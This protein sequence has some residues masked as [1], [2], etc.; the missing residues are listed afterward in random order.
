MPGARCLVV[1]PE[2]LRMRKACVSNL[3]KAALLEKEERDCG[4]DDATDLAGDRG[5]WPLAYLAASSVLS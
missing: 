5:A 3:F 2:V 4:P 1:V